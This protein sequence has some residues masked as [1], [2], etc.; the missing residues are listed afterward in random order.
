MVG[1][2]IRK[3]SSFGVSEINHNV[4]LM[5][6]FSNQIVPELQDTNSAIR[7]MVK[8]SSLK[9]VATF[10]NQFNRTE[11]LALMPLLMNHLASD[12]VVVHTLA[13]YTI[14]RILWMKETDPAA[15][16]GGVLRPKLSRADLQPFLQ[17]LFGNL[18]NIVDNIVLNENEYVMKCIMRSLDRAGADV[19]P[20]TGVVFEKLASALERVCKNPRN[21]GFNHN[22]F[23]SIALL[24]KN[25]CSADSTRIGD[26]EALLFPPFQSILQLDVAE[27]S[28]YVFQIL[29]QLLEYRPAGAGLGD[30]YS[31]LLPPLLT[32]EL[33]D[34]TGNVPALVRLLQAYLKRAASDLVGHLVSLLGIFQKLLASKA[35]E[36][37]SMDLLSSLTIYVPHASM[38]PY[39]KDVFHMILVRLNGTKSNKFPLLVVQYFGL[40][41]GLY[42]GMAYF[43]T[44]DSIQPGV[45]NNVLLNVWLRHLLNAANSKVAAKSQ[46]VGLTRVLLCDGLLL[47]NDDGKQVWGQALHGV[48]ALLASPSLTKERKDLSEEVSVAYD[49]TFSQLRYAQ[50]VLDDPFLT[51]ADPLDYFLSSLKALSASHP[52]ALVPI[53]QQGLSSDPKLATTFSAM[54]ESKGI[55]LA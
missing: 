40:F 33:W 27:F 14:E 31:S 5:E 36:Q 41:S 11:L 39:C 16:S 25:C 38:Q 34:R 50:K 30:A 29:A 22:L 12:V 15:S 17:T 2:T 28:P 26:L 35:T 21:P 52:G 24:V 44:M 13:A 55:L 20:V 48:V 49:A 19:I 42:G 32:A 46:V 9:F 47:T 23:E 6:F 53:I 43:D 4:N 1:I 8:A 51:V 7:P 45:G 54:C 18:F 10:R 3:E 37:G